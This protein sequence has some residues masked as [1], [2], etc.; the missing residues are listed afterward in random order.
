MKIFKLKTKFGL[1]K[2][3]I[4]LSVI[5]VFA[6]GILL[7]VRAEDDYENTVKYARNNAKQLSQ[8]VTDHLTLTLFSVDM[9]MKKMIEKHNSLSHIEDLADQSIHGNITA[10]GSQVPNLKALIITDEYG[11]VRTLYVNDEFKNFYFRGTSL[12]E[13]DYFLIHKVGSYIDSLYIDS[14]LVGH[15]RLN[16][17]I[18]SRSLKKPD[19]SFDGIVMAAVDNSYL[20]NFLSSMKDFRKNKLA[21]FSRDSGKLLFSQASDETEF[22]WLGEKIKPDSGF[23]VTQDTITIDDNNNQKTKELR[24][25]TL[26]SLPNFN[27][28]L[29]LM[30]HG[31]DVLAGWKLDR[32]NDIIFFGIMMLFA[33]AAGVFAHI[34]TKQMQ[35]VEASERTAVLASQTKSEFLANISHELRTPLNAIIGFSEMMDAGYFGPLNAKQ[36]ERMQDISSCGSHLLE[37]INDVLEFSKAD[38]GKL[39]LREKRCD[40]AKI[41]DDSIRIFAE[42]ARVEGKELMANVSSSIPSVRADE[43]KL[44]QIVINLIANAVKFT[45]KGGHIEVSANLDTDKNILLVVKDNG[46]GIAPEDI[47]KALSVFGQAHSQAKYGGTGLGLPLS[48]MLV[49]LHGGELRLESLKGVGTKVTIMLPTSR[50]VYGY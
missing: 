8:I 14:D 15:T 5:M 22:K 10:W 20:L 28:I 18:L 9:T 21:I 43:R 44:K 25:Y 48:K 37:L 40:I 13:K 46:I 2:I 45:N 26:Q 17:M 24:I 42:R 3:L 39:E 6:L 4:L 31:D 41:I 49:E 32:I 33:A 11:R 1:A 34:L 36:K 35:K 23:V 29:S 38:A 50:L 7:Y 30:V 12:A 16:H 47:P 19:G 27:I